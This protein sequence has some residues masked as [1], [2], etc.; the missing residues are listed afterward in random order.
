[1]VY[2]IVRTS[3]RATHMNHAGDQVPAG[4]RL[5]TPDL[6]YPWMGLIEKSFCNGSQNKKD[7]QALI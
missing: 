2:A 3:L 5:V 6:D 4:T 1:M 7:W